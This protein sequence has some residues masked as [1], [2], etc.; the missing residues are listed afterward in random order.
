MTIMQQSNWAPDRTLDVWFQRIQQGMTKR[1]HL[2][3]LETS[4]L[5]RITSLANTFIDNLNV[6][7]ALNVAGVKKFE[8]RSVGCATAD[9]GTIA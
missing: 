4:D 7:V 6:E 3:G 8:A 9:S 1:P 2:Q 5:S